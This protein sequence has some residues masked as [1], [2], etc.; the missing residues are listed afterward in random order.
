MTGRSAQMPRFRTHSRHK[1]F[2]ISVNGTC[3]RPAENWKQTAPTAAAVGHAYRRSAPS[4]AVTVSCGAPA[5]PSNP[6]ADRVESHYE[7]ARGAD[8]T[9]TAP[10][11][12]RRR[13]CQGFRTGSSEQSSGWRRR[14]LRCPFSVL[15]SS[16]W[17]TS[18][19]SRHVPFRGV[20][21]PVM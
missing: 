9:T 20:F 3:A 1:K 16:S 15:W 10:A 7:R 21:A 17:P 12:L 11:R 18:V 13:Q 5:H 4:T 8:S 2:D 19:S 14:A 6:L